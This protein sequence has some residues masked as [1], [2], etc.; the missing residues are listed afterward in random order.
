M[1]FFLILGSLIASSLIS[2]CASFSAP[3]PRP[4][5]AG[6]DAVDQV[7]PADIVGTWKMRVLNPRPDEQLPEQTMTLNADGSAKG[8]I[9]NLPDME[10]SGLEFESSAN[11]ELN[12]DIVT[13]SNV[14]VREL[15]G[16][17][18]GSFMTAIVNTQS[19]KM[20][21]SA[22]VMEVSAN[23][24]VWAWSEDGTVMEYVRTE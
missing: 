6:V 19:K 23:R 16:N 17:S 21:G 9:T 3:P 7:D 12:G 13:T 24:M 8:S 18:L 4:A 14:S 15:S 1:K 20:S 22:N 2:A 10:D 5:Y 11:W